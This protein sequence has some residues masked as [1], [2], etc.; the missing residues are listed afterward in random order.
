MRL[1][2]GNI[3][4]DGETF[5]VVFPDLPLA[6]TNGHSRE[7]ALAHAPDALH[8]AI[9]MLMEKN[10]NIPIPGKTGRNGVTVGLAS[11]IQSAKVE[12]Y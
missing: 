4:R 5:V 6:H 11:V 12:L 1:Y 7:D 8:A 3:K 10:E 9:S 2:P